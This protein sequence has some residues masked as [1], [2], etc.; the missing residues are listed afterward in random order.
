M[1][2]IQETVSESLR[3]QNLGHYAQ[4]AAPVVTALEGRERQICEDLINFA[5]SQGM[6]RETVRRAISETGMTMPALVAVG[7][8]ASADATNQTPSQDSDVLQV[9]SQINAQLSGLTQFARDNGY[10][11]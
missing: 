9:L 4:H 3:Q 10:Q 8:V 1:S 5:T 7:T 6:D 11:G 2:S